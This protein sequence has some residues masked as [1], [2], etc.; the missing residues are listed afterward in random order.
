MYNRGKA[1][2]IPVFKANNMTAKLGIMYTD[3]AKYFDLLLSSK[4]QRLLTK[5]LPTGLK[6]VA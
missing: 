4:R 2:Q 6:T 1:G 5:N 3:I